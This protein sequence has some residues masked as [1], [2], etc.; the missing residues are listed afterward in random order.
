[1]T[2]SSRRRGFTLVE[3][4]VVIAIIG[5]LIGMLLPAVQ[6]VREAARRTQCLNNMRQLGLGAL[7]F[8][9]AHMHFPTAGFAGSDVW[10]TNAVQR[11][12]R[13]LVTAD[14]AP[15]QRAAE[16]AG[17]LW[18]ILPQIEQNNLVRLRENGIFNVGP[19]SGLVAA[20]Q[21]VPL[22]SCPSRGP[23]VF[24]QGLLRLAVVDYANPSSASNAPG[25]DNRRGNHATN[26]DFWRSTDWHVGMIR[27]LGA[28]PLQNRWNHGGNVLDLVHS[29]CGFGQLVDGSSNTAMLIEKS[30]WAQ[31]YN[32]V[33]AQ[34]DAWRAFGY[35]GG[36]F[37]PGFRTNGRS[38]WPFIAD[39]EEF[40][41]STFPWGG[42]NP[43]VN[44]GGFSQEQWFGSA[45][46]GTVNMLLGDGSTHAASMDT[47][48]IVIHQLSYMND[49]LVLDHSAF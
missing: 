3:L 5:I 35:T 2:S 9:S 1:M 48:H 47:Q 46:P 7:N 20:E 13:S 6:Q 21:V 36:Q 37:A 25:V 29:K 12:A 45:H 28:Q 4:L 43:R 30:A 18:Q 44:S 34:N 40:R 41:P 27:V 17:W 14:N 24:T 26:Q 15:H 10:W 31:Q 19:V 38:P 42:G 49:G 22:A 39:N 23:R 11:G 16:G 32:P 33:V 8:E